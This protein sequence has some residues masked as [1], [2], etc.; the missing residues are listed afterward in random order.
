LNWDQ[1]FKEHEKQAYL[2]AVK[3]IK[4]KDD[5]FDI[6]QEA[7]ISMYKNYEDVNQLEAKPLFYKILNSKMT[8]KYRQLKRLWNRFS[9]EEIEMEYNCVSE[10]RKEIE[11]LQKELDKLSSTQ[12][13]VFLLKTVEEMTFKEIAI[14]LSMSEST[15]KTHYS[16]GLKKIQESVNHNE[17]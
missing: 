1:F 12:Q 13:R 17:N 16:R 9:S 11:L 10:T 14:S 2:I 15:A 6:V 7:M 4:N 8:D 3:Y 5:A